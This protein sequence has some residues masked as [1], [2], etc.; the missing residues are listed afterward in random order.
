MP[1]AY[2]ERDHY[3]HVRHTEREQA[4]AE[5]AKQHH[6]VADLSQLASLGFTG[7]QVTRRVKQ[8]RLTNHSRTVYQIGPGP[9]SQLGRFRAALLAGGEDAGLVGRSAAALH[10]VR[11]DSRDV[12]DI[13]TPTRRRS[14]D[15][16]IAHW[17]PLDPEDLTTVDGW[18]VTTVARTFLDLALTHPQRVPRAMIRAERQFLFDLFAI[19]GAI[20]RAPRHRGRPA[21]EKALNEYHPLAHLTRSFAELAYLLLIT[22][23]GLPRPLVNQQPFL[24]EEVDFHWPELK[25]VVEIDGPDHDTAYQR[26][27]DQARDA[28]LEQHGW[29]VVRVTDT[30]VRDRPGHVLAQTRL[31][32]AKARGRLAA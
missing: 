30:D 18:R 3:G 23:H 27:K 20:S 26:A 14:R 25:L 7:R 4:L 17:A 1:G 15:G 5:W 22:K 6:C 24:N 2:D 28:L 13:A 31:A 12:V 11:P 10:G 21:V 8:G 9:L 16:V 19:D 32:F 29:R